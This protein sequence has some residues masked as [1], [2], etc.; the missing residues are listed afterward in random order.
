MTLEEMYRKLGGD[1]GDV[2]LR[3]PSEALIRRFAV[4][5]LSDTTFADLVEAVEAQDWEKAFRA[6]HTMKGVALNLGFGTLCRTASE[7]TEALRSRE[8]LT[9]IFHWEPEMGTLSPLFEFPM[10]TFSEKDRFSKFWTQY[11]LTPKCSAGRGRPHKVMWGACA[12]I[13]RRRSPNRASD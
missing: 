13:C 11:P 9:W 7:L 5:F 8:P 2:R 1:Y 6:A 10:T 3:I 4:K 12:R